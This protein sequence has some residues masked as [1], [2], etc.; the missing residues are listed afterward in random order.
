MGLDGKVECVR[1]QVHRFAAST[2]RLDAC[3]ERSTKFGDWASEGAH[4]GYRVD[5]RWWRPSRGC[6]WLR[7]DALAAQLGGT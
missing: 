3:K 6:G 7:L 5:R 4:L 1:D 2:A